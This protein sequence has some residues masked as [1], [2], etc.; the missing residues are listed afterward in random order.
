MWQAM[1]KDT[2]M[3]SLKN[4]ERELV[5][6]EE[7]LTPIFQEEGEGNTWRAVKRKHA[8]RRPKW[9]QV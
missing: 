5:H 2:D 1:G 6:V 3:E 7:Y 4:Q 8:T 9:G